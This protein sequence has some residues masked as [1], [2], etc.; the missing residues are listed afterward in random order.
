MGATSPQS[1]A[2]WHNDVSLN[3]IFYNYTAKKNL[4]LAYKLCCSSLLVYTMTILQGVISCHYDLFCSCKTQNVRAIIDGQH[5]DQRVDSLWNYQF[6]IRQHFSHHYNKH[7][8]ITICGSV[9]LFTFA[10]RTQYWQLPTHTASMSYP[11]AT[12]P[13]DI[14]AQF[15]LKYVISRWPTVLLMVMTSSKLILANII[16]P[17]WPIIKQLKNWSITNVSFIIIS[18]LCWK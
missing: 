12:S 13:S 11:Y 3:N 1:R 8:A 7:E 2:S 6:W 16:S 15:H 9:F 14:F 18:S 10:I 4:P 17:N 5:Y